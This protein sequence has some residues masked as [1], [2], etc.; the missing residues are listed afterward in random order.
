MIQRDRDFPLWEASID[1]SVGV[2]SLDMH[3]DIRCGPS[4]LVARNQ[5]KNEK[6]AAE[7][8]RLCERMVQEL[9]I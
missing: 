5:H 7:S 8:M 6:T 3:V 9:G 2:P 1:T 4:Y